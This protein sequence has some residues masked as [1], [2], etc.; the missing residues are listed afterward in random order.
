MQCTAKIAIKQPLKLKKVTTFWKNIRPGQY[1]PYGVF[2]F[3]N[4]VFS[5]SMVHLVIGVKY[6]VFVMAYLK[7][8]IVYKGILHV[9]F[10]ILDSVLCIWNGIF[11]RTCV[12]LVSLL[13]Y[14]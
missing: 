6:L 14:F 2:S 3:R 9:T 4:Q 12:L 11:H 10:C 7:I 5:I 8:G 1:Q 13:T